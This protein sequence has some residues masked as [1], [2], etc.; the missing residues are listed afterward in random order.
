[1]ALAI[2]A[3]HTVSHDGD[4]ARQASHPANRM[5][6][7]FTVHGV[8]ASVS[9]R[10]ALDPACGHDEKR[11][12]PAKRHRRMLISRRLAANSAPGTSSADVEILVEP[13][14]C[15][16]RSAAGATPD[17]TPRICDLRL[18]LQAKWEGSRAGSAKMLGSR[19]CHGKSSRMRV[20]YAVVC[21]FEIPWAGLWP[22][23]WP[24]L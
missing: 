17:R 23:E 20:S 22:R 9:A 13:G 21:Q 5:V 3:E 1:M 12:Q 15:K 18:E 11:K 19:R 16:R 14:P 10:G 2:Q 7:L 6:R 8:L 4:V 24:R